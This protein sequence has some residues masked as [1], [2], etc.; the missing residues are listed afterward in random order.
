MQVIRGFRTG[1]LSAS[2][3]PRAAP[4]LPR[5]L[6]SLHSACSV[7]GYNQLGDH[8]RLPSLSDLEGVHRAAGR[9]SRAHRGTQLCS[10]S[11]SKHLL[12]AAAM[13]PCRPAT[14]SRAGAC[15]RPGLPPLLLYCSPRMMPRQAI[16][17]AARTFAAQQQA[18]QRQSLERQAPASPAQSPQQT[19]PQQTA[20][21]LQRRLAP[22]RQ[23]FSILR[24]LIMDKQVGAN[25]SACKSHFRAE[26]HAR[27]SSARMSLPFPQASS[28]SVAGDH[29]AGGHVPGLRGAAVRAAAA[30]CRGQHQPEEGQAAADAAQPQ[31][32]ARCAAADRRR[33]AG[34]GK[35]CN[36]PVYEMPSRRRLK[37]TASS[38]RKCS[39]K[40]AKCCWCRTKARRGSRTP[41]QRRAPPSSSGLT[42]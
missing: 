41:M 20:L 37:Q 19:A 34:P 1:T 2:T 5:E 25:A 29:A 12:P 38:L 3:L 18:L 30:D 17:P 7:P 4:R 13:Q 26:S 36:D 32:S 14:A 33:A 39:D 27:R 35:D 31:Y 24:S 40:L 42:W 6:H 23:N 15:L 28:H 8:P 11:P 21:A 22:R 16:R 9:P 10:I